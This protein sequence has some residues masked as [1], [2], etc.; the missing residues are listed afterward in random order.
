MRSSNRT[1]VAE[2]Y[3]KA[4][5]WHRNGPEARKNHALPES[6]SGDGKWVE[7]VGLKAGAALRLP[8]PK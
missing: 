6:T 1:A 3:A 8:Q 2:A 7:S 4:G 5:D